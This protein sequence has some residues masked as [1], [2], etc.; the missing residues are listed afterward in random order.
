MQINFTELW[1]LTVDAFMKEVNVMKRRFILFGRKQQENEEVEQV[2]EHSVIY[3]AAVIL[4]Q[5]RSP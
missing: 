4:V 2:Y 1:K 3:P 5:R